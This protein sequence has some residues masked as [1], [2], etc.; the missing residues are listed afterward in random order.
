M[1]TF[2]NQIW[3]FGIKILWD[4]VYHLRTIDLSGC[5]T[6]SRTNLQARTPPLSNPS[7]ANS[8]SR[9]GLRRSAQK[10][11]ID[12]SVAQCISTNNTAWGRD[13][14]KTVVSQKNQVILRTSKRPDM[15]FVHKNTDPISTNNTAWGRDGSKT[16]VS[17]KNQVILRTS[18]R[19]DMSFIHKNTDPTS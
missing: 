12:R 3:L 6:P 15:S 5:T 19:P 13:G 18:K 11:R 16:V 1:C 4:R 2:F 17:Q 14:S 7:P 9:P 10:K 8:R